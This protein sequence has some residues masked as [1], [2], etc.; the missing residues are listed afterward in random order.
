MKPLIALLLLSLPAA[1][2]LEPATS[3]NPAPPS[4]PPLSPAPTLRPNPARFAN[5]IEAFNRQEPEKGGIVFTGSSSIRLWPHLKE[6]FPGL[7]VTNRGFGGCV[8]NDMIVYFDSIVTR[9]EPK[10]L[11]T[12]CGSNDIQEHL[13]VDE[14]FADYTKFLGIAHDRFPATRIILTSVKIAPKRA[15]HIPRIHEFN[16]RLE[17][18]VTGKDWVRY[19]D[20]T[21]Y[22][23]DASD[24]PIIS[25]Y[26]P[27]NLHLS[28]AG[29]AKWQAILDPILREE[30]AKVK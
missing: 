20:C 8:S 28:P 10:V 22:L 21:S 18:W 4:N 17:A 23:A 5:E 16:R 2:A 7:P 11:V 29:Y 19:V 25:Y 13:T 14:A 26:G 3:A 9:H 12:Y 6:D 27:D 30:W 24:Q 15:T 1:F